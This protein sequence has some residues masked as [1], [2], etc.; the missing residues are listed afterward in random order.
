M[1]ECIKRII[2]F[3]RESDKSVF[4]TKDCSFHSSAYCN[5]RD[6][7]PSESTDGRGRRWKDNKVMTLHV[8]QQMEVGSVFTIPGVNFF[9]PIEEDSGYEMKFRV[10]KSNGNKVVVSPSVEE[11]G[12]YKNVTRIPIA[13]DLAIVEEEA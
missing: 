10:V 2:C 9:T 12:R 7:V 13:G 6:C 4:L 11:S 3:D 1:F 8:S 5:T